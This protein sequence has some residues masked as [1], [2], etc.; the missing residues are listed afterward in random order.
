MALYP[1]LEEGQHRHEQRVCA[2]RLLPP[3]RTLRGVGRGLG[4]RRQVPL[5]RRAHRIAPPRERV[6]LVDRA[7]RLWVAARRP[8]LG[9]EPIDAEA[10]GGVVGDLAE[11]P[12]DVDAGIARRRDLGP[13]LV[14]A[15]RHHRGL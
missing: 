11:Q 9:G 10:D 7:L 14:V 2:D 12:R 13:G 15:P 4:V 5:H 8:A 3:R 6:E 1:A